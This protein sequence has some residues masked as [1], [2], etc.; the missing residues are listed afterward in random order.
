VDPRGLL[1]VNI[2]PD[3]ARQEAVHRGEPIGSNVALLW[4]ITWPKWIIFLP[5]V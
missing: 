1:F 3:A 5:L 2:G 4:V